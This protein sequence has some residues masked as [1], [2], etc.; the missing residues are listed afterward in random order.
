MEW[1]SGG[2]ATSRLKEFG[3][4]FIIRLE[5]IPPSLELIKDRL[6]SLGVWFTVHDPYRE[7]YEL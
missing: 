7:I 6:K 1:K 5:E 3:L 4:G 2:A